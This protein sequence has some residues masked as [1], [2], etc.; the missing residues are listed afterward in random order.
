MGGDA[1]L[2]EAGDL[3]VQVV[4]G[5]QD[6]PGRGELGALEDALGQ[7]R[8]VDARH[9]GVE[10]HQGEGPA[11]G[12][13]TPQGVEGLQSVGDRRRLGPPAA[14]PSFEDLAIGR[15]VVHDE[16]AEALELDQRRH[17]RPDGLVGLQAESRREMKRTA[18]A[19]LALD[20][21]LAAHQGDQPRRDRQAQPRPAI[22]AGRLSCLPARMP[23]RSSAACRPG[24]RCPYR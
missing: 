7:G 10:H 5:Q 2:A 12:R 9:P 18:P 8:A 15:V 22:P 20:A 16:D 4:G 23:G 1:Q 21:D 3:A 11:R 14:E 6:D 13:R 19:R 24:C 17:H